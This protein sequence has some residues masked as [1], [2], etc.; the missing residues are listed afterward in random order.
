MDRLNH[1]TESALPNTSCKHCNKRFCFDSQLRQHL[2]TFH[3]GGGISARPADLNQP[4]VG[5]S[6]YQELAAYEEVL[7]QHMDVIKSDEINQTLWKRINREIEPDF[8]YGNLKS[9]LDGLMDKEVSVFKINIG[10]GVILYNTVEQI[11][12]YFY[13][14]NN[15]Y[16]FEKSVTISN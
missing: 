4:I 12:K 8:T 14:S 2:V 5:Q 13:V 11:F 7:A 16:L 15:S 3:L 1:H 9:L 10:F 6:P